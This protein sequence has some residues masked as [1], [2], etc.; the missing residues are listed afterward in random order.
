MDRCIN[1]VKRLNTRSESWS[2]S[3]WA[4]SYLYAKK[5]RTAAWGHAQIKGRIKWAIDPRRERTVK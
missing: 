4:R 3:R 5:I 2:M 1:R